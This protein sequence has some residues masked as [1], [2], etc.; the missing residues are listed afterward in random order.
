MEDGMYMVN[1]D[2]WLC[3]FFTGSQTAVKSVETK[4]EHTNRSHS[5]SVINQLLWNFSFVLTNHTQC[6]STTEWLKKLTLS[7]K[8]ILWTN[9]ILR[10]VRFYKECL[11]SEFGGCGGVYHNLSTWETE[12]RGKS[13]ILQIHF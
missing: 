1:H 6:H 12:T 8:V 2:E 10:Q 3:A 11:W 4:T 9:K 7:Y 5:H 13:P